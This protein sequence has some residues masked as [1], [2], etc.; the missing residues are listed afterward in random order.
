MKIRPSENTKLYGLDIYFNEIIELYNEKKMPNKIL[1][2]GKKGLGKSTLA[3]H[4]INKILSEKE[5]N[6][7]DSQKL[8]INSENRSYKLLKNNLHPNF[9]LIDLLD[10]KK[11]IDISQI[12]DMIIYSNKSSFNNSPRFILIDNIENLNKN[13]VNALLK[14][15]EEPNDNMF[16]ILI[17]NN[18][19]T[20]LP[21]LKSRCLTFKINFSFIESIN[22]SNL[23]LKKNI[24]EL[25]NYDLIS[26]YSTPGEIIKLIN[27]ANEKEIDLTVLKLS[28]I[29]NLL[30]DKGYYKKNKF[31]KYLII[32]F[33]EL[34]FLKEYKLSLTKKSLLDIYK[35]FLV[36][37]KNTEKFNLDEESLFLEFKSKLLD[38]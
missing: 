23:L 19:K 12:R 38:G 37:I 36:K 24:S 17:H 21:T 32:N 4:L 35:I 31:V 18:E 14:I 29:L 6:K 15:V 20:I 8:I 13:S 33:I 16:F 22:V 5:E 10:E 25:I 34:F 11:N 9:Y 28:D 3:Y 2:S 27:F 1:L 26:Y 30:I 7:Y